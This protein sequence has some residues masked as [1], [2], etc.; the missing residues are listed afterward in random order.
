MLL[1]I[2]LDKVNKFNTKNKFNIAKNSTEFKEKQS[3]EIL[4]LEA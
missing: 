3:Q 4:K 2:K 1:E